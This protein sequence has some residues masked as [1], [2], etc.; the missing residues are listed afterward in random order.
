MSHYKYRV[1]VVSIEDGIYDTVK[2]LV[3]K[4]LPS[5]IKAGIKMLGYKKDMD[6][7]IQKRRIRCH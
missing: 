3:K 7:I 4:N 5:A 1:S 6:V 2:P